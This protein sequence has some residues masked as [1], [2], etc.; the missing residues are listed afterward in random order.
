MVRASGCASLPFN[1]RFTIRAEP[2][3]REAAAPTPPAVAPRSHRAEE[4]VRRAMV[5]GIVGALRTPVV[6]AVPLSV[7]YLLNGGWT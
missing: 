2:P 1:S 6:I 7:L 5:P 4:D 3:V